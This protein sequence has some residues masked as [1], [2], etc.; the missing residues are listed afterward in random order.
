M[1]VHARRGDLADDMVAVAVGHKAGQ[2]IAFAVA[3]A[4]EGS[5][6]HA[7][8]QGQGVGETAAQ[9]IRIKGFLR[10]AADHAHGNERGGVDVACAENPAAAVGHKHGFSRREGDERGTLHVDFV[11]EYPQMAC[12]QTAVFAF[13]QENGFHGTMIRVC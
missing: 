5:L 4:V 11:A 9:K 8:A 10:P 6:K 13:F 3:E 2:K 12:A 7:F 1:N